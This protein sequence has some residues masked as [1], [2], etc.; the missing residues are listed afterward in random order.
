MFY[1]YCRKKDQEDNVLCPLQEDSHKHKCKEERARARALCDDKHLAEELQNI[2]DVFVA[3][4]YPRETVRRFM[5]PRPQQTDKR[6]Q[7][8]QEDRGVVT[9]TYLKGVSE[10]FWRTANRH[11]F[12][13]AFKPGRK[14]KEIKRK[15]QEPL[16]ER[17][18]CVVYK[19]PC[20]CQNTVYV[21][22]TWRLFQTR[23]KE[24]MH[25]V[26]LTNEDLRKGNTLS[27][28]KRIGKE[29]GGLAR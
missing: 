8:E 23:K 1:R 11:S 20:A 3:N 25:K 12:R 28:E 7:E 22:E 13:V 19:I 10:Q 2:E 24:H 26:R 15:C 29:D 5:D 17:Q 9:I 14:I 18:K 21:G 6:E 27:A 16:G 4:G